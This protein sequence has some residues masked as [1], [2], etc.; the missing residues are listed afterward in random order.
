MFGVF[1]GMRIIITEK[2]LS[3]LQLE[4]GLMLATEPVEVPRFDLGKSVRGSTA[5]RLETPEDDPFG[6]NSNC[7]YNSKEK[8]MELFKEAKS[9]P[10][11]PSDW[12]AIKPIADKMYSAMKGL[13]SGNI[14]DLFKGINTKQKLSALVKNWKYDGQDLSTWM[15]DEY[16]VNWN[17]LVKVLSVNFNLPLCRPG[18]KC[19][20]S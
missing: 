11:S 20:Y 4:Q 19:R 5:K 1:I 16:L 13:G 9:W 17:N 12:T 15:K 2:Q 7:E 14:V 3:K 10:S 18:C 6:N 8:T